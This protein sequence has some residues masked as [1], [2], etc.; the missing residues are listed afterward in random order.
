MKTHHLNIWGILSGALLMPGI[1]LATLQPHRIWAG[2]RHS[3]G[4]WVLII[5]DSIAGF[6]R[7]TLFGSLIYATARNASV[8][9]GPLGGTTA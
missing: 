7:Y 5:Q 3:G 8:Q 4:I 1:M 9:I 6:I 2:Y